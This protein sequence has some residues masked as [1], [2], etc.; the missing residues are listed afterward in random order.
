MS[1][2]RASRPALKE[3]VEATPAGLKPAPTPDSSDIS[4]FQTHRHMSQHKPD[5]L[6][7][8]QRY[9]AATPLRIAVGLYAVFSVPAYVWLEGPVGSV[10]TVPSSTAFISLLAGSILIVPLITHFVNQRFV[11]G[12]STDASE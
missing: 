5:A 7:R 2:C 1:V 9:V 4:L 8:A 10:G 11:R 3:R 6:E 12:R